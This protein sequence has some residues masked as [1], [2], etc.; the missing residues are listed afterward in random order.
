ML[1]IPSRRNNT[2]RPKLL[3][4]RVL[5]RTLGAEIAEMDT[6]L[7]AFM[8]ELSAVCFLLPRV[9]SMQVSMS[10]FRLPSTIHA[11][12]SMDRLKFHSITL[13]HSSRFY[14]MDPSARVF[15]PRSSNHSTTNGANMSYFAN[16]RN[17]APDPTAGLQVEFARLA[18]DQGWGRK[19]KKRKEEWRRACEDEFEKHFGAAFTGGRLLAWQNLCGELGVDPIPGSITQCK[20]VCCYLDGCGSPAEWYFPRR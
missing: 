11:R 19:S 3:E 4:S 20:K 16:F 18:I 6:L 7:P 15:I 14:S 2:C 12:N 5:D 8:K 13:N 9:A 17:F 10:H 1:T